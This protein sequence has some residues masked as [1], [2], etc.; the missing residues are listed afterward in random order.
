[1]ICS[2]VRLEN[3]GFFCKKSAISWS[4]CAFDEHR[5]ARNVP[6]STAHSVPLPVH[7]IVAARGQLYSKANSPNASPSVYDLTALPGRR[8]RCAEYDPLCTM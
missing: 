1:M 8:A 5:I 7:L 6:R 4:L 2:E 3:N